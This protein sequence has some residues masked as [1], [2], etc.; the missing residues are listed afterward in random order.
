MYQ[1]TSKCFVLV[2]SIL[3][4]NVS[5]LMEQWAFFG[6]CSIFSSRH[7]ATLMDRHARSRRRRLGGPTATPPSAPPRRRGRIDPMGRMW[8]VGDDHATTGGSP[9]VAPWPPPPCT[10]GGPPPCRREP[11]A[12]LRAA[13][14]RQPVVDGCP[15]FGRSEATISSLSGGLLVRVR[16]SGSPLCRPVRSPL[17]PLLRATGSSTRLQ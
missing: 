15:A 9:R 7:A 6:S 8:P 5:M 14:I 12:G 11:L 17:L 10:T 13:A 1:T 3:A 2:S 4:A 16:Y